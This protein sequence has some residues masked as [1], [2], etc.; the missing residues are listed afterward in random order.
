MSLVIAIRKESKRPP[1]AILALNLHLDLDG[2]A[3]PACSDG[4]Q[5]A[6]IAV[7][8]KE[9]LGLGTIEQRK[10]LADDAAAVGFRDDQLVGLRKGFRKVSHG[11]DLLGSDLGEIKGGRRIGFAADKGNAGE[12]GVRDFH[13]T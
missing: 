8:G 9:S 1:G 4:A 6:R 13:R 5:G 11:Y 12:E 7:C 10:G 2:I 3:C